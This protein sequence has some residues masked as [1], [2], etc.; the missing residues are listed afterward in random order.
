[1]SARSVLR[2]VL[3]RLGPAWRVHRR[4]HPRAAARVE[5]AALA[6]RGGL[7][8]EVRA[9][10][11][12][13]ADLERDHLLLAAHVATLTEQLDAAT[14]IGPV[15]RDA[16]AARQRARLAAIAFYEE[17]ISRL[18]ARLGGRGHARADADRMS[19]GRTPG[20]RAAAA[21]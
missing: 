17:R 1:M 7:P 10:R 16:E 18:E 2:G 3:G 21:S 9:L 11:A 14:R 5:A 19:A 8:E 15:D 13:V 4:R 6:V 12:R 20:E